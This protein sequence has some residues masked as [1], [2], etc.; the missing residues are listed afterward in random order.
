MA[1]SGTGWSQMRNMHPDASMDP[2]SNSIL[3]L[4]CCKATDRKTQTKPKPFKRECETNESETSFESARLPP[5]M[6]SISYPIYSKRPHIMAIAG[7]E[8]GTV[9]SL[10]RLL[11]YAF[12]VSNRVLAMTPWGNY[13]V[14]KHPTMS[15]NSYLFYLFDGCICDIDRFRHLDL[16]YGTAGLLPF[17]TKSQVICYMIDSRETRS[18]KLLNTTLDDSRRLFEEFMGRG[19]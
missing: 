5:D 7:S 1:T 16:N 13:V 2:K 6:N 12:K 8:S 14:F 19:A 9:E 15:G 18:S 10:K 17:K 4:T 3:L 11:N